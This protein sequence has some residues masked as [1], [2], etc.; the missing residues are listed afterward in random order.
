MSKPK[1]QKGGFFCTPF[2]KN[3]SSD[4]NIAQNSMEFSSDGQ[5]L[6]FKKESAYGVPKL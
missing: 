1:N 5:G 4:L 3:L 2:N 6:V